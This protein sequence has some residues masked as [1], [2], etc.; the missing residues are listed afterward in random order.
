MTSARDQIISKTCELFEN[1]G[2]HATGINQIVKESGAPKGSIYY[3]F[4]DGKEEIAIE[5]VNRSGQ[6][7]SA[8]IRE[9]L[10]EAEDVLEA[11]PAFIRQIAHFVEA[12]G[13]QSGGPLAAIAME[14]AATNEKI[15][16]A[17]REAYQMIEGAFRDRLLESGFS[18]VRAA[19]L[20]TFITASIEG[21]VILSRTY[22]SG[23]PLREAADQIKCL[24][25]EK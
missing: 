7:M 22:H 18:K 12:S 5:A 1:Q 19:R 23:E 6:I 21:G 25:K 9:S 15:N 10:A 8:R 17:C 2:Y 3:Y 14:T 20:A 11:I 13:Y 4:P 16:L 24:L